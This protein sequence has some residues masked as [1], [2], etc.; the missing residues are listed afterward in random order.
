M[1]EALSSQDEETLQTGLAQLV[2]AELLY[3]QGRPPRAKYLFK[4][5]L[6]QDT[7]YASLLRSTRQRVH[8]QIAELLEARFPETVER[9]PEVV[10]HHYTEAGLHELA[11]IYWQ[12][13]GQRAGEQSANREAVHHLT[14]GLELLATLPDRDERPQQELG[15]QMVLGPALMAT[16]GYAGRDVERAYARARQL[17]QQVGETPQ[18]FPV[19]WGLC[20]F[21]TTRGELQTARELEDQLLRLAQRQDDPDLLM[22]AH[23]AL[24]QT[25]FYLGEFALARTHL[26]Q[27]AATN[28][29]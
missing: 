20:R 5:A 2:A 6:I 29:K 16:Q 27:G 14:R 13:A 18:L 1:L 10:A 3:Q 26:E 22:A 4:H 19:L 11:I 28:K 7:A 23:N 15:F 24:G 8:R 17:C 9:Q 25:L 12:Q 21:Y